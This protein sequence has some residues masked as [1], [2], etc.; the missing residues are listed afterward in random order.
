MGIFNSFRKSDESTTSTVPNT[1][2]PNL[3]IKLTKG[4]ENL[5]KAIKLTKEST[6]I[7]ISALKVRIAFVIDKSGSMEGL[8][9]R[10]DVQGILTDLLPAAIQFDDNGEAEVFVFSNNCQQ[11]STPMTEKNF[12]NYVDKYLKSFSYGGTQYAPAVKL[13]DKFYNDSESQEIPTLVFFITDG[14]NFDS[15]K[16]PTDAA[17]RTSAEHGIFYQFI[18]IGSDHFPYLESIDDLDGRSCDNTGFMKVADFKTVDTADVFLKSLKDFVPWLKTK[19]Y[20]K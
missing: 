5:N 9:N 7:D 4:K 10:G 19:G 14:D 6:G 20:I 3:Q 13:T 1:A 12:E 15:D 17:I 18:G 16:R 2:A 8:Y 11:V